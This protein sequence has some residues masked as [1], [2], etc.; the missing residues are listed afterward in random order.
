VFEAGAA[1][2]HAAN[3]VPP[4]REF[5]RTEQVQFLVSRFKNGSFAAI[6]QFG[7]VT[8]EIPVDARAATA[9]ADSDSVFH[10]EEQVWAWSVAAGLQPFAAA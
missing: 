8:E 10:H 2:S 3:F 5:D 1:Q 9:A 4:H 6:R 7:T